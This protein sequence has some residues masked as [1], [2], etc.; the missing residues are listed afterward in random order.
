V[1]GVRITMNYCNFAYSA[2]ACFRMGMSGSA[3]FQRAKEIL[4]RRFGLGGVALH[5][6]GSPDLEMREC[7]DG[8]VTH[9]STMVALPNTLRRAH[10][11]DTWASN[12]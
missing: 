2:L 4:I 11:L 12:R 5:G 1:L 9:N 8:F 3:S 7:A 6:V 10:R